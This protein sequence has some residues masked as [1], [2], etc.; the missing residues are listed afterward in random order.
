MKDRGLP[1]LRSPLIRNLSRL[2]IMPGSIMAKIFPHMELTLKQSGVSETYALNTRSY[3]AITVTVAVIGGLL[4]G[5]AVSLPL[6][7]SGKPDN[8]LAG[9][10]GIFV[11]V[12]MVVYMM[13]YPTSIVNKRVKYI[14]RNLL[15][16]LRSILVQIRSGVPIF[17][18]FVSIA[19]GDYGPIST[20][21]KIFV[22]KVNAG[23]PMVET[24]EELA[25]R[26]PSMYFRRALWQLVNGIKAGS[27]V[28][29]NLSDIITTLSKEQ[30]VEVRRYKSILNPLAMMYMMVAVIMPSL[31]ITLL[32]ILSSIPGAASSLA[33]EQTFW[34]LLVIF[35]ILQG[36]FMMI[37]RSKRPNLIGG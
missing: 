22:E 30:L 29:D 24:L 21:L 1:I 25:I 35:T 23:Q 33:N 6:S 27:N 36:I 31:S 20:E 26:N 9:L 8:M 19:N 16:A 14:E 4:S 10:I 18:S 2:F 11:G 7:A 17:N 28:G 12:M 34:M 5:G 15:F 37:I 3:F 13:A 32:I